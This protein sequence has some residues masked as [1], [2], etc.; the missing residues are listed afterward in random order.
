MHLTPAQRDALILLANETRAQ[1]AA[2][3]SAGHVW[4]PRTLVARLFATTDALVDAGLVRFRVVEHGGGSGR[5]GAGRWRSRAVREL[6][7]TPDG[8]LQVAAIRAAVASQPE[9]NPAVHWTEAQVARV[10]RRLG[11]DFARIP[12]AEFRRG[13]SVELEHGRHGPGGRA[14]DVTHDSALLTGKIALA[15]LTEDPHYYTKLRRVEDN[16]R[17][18]IADVRVQR[19]IRG[20]APRIDASAKARGLEILRQRGA[21]SGAEYGRGMQGLNANPETVELR[22]YTQGTED[23]RAARE[24]KKLIA[25]YERQIEASHGKPGGTSLREHLHDTIRRLRQVGSEE[26]EEHKNTRM[27][28]RRAFWKAT[29]QLRWATGALARSQPVSAFWHHFAEWARLELRA[30]FLAIVLRADLTGSD[31]EDPALRNH[32][33]NTVCRPL[34]VPLYGLRK[35]ECL[36][37]WMLQHE[38]EHRARLLERFAAARMVTA[39]QWEPTQWSIHRDVWDRAKANLISV[40]DRYG[41]AD[42]GPM[43]ASQRVAKHNRLSQVGEPL[44]WDEVM[45]GLDASYTDPQHLGGAGQPTRELLRGWLDRHSLEGL[46]AIVEREEKKAKRMREAAEE[47][48]ARPPPPPEPPPPP[49]EPVR[50]PP[51]RVGAWKEGER[52]GALFGNPAGASLARLVARAARS[53]RSVGGG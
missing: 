18:T 7:L 48:P 43:P 12:F 25:K 11:V 20:A 1:T 51:R 33:A 45:D 13:M 8:E 44:T 49:P 23:P 39:Q 10:G 22:Y 27:H 3:R 19:A 29:E 35:Y 15:H 50:A 4:I 52:Q 41:Y 24:R 17:A 46:E 14:L 6:Q 40:N 36:N 42:P 21:L 31:T 37:A 53:A 47:A 38:L 2:G 26:R 16:P 28:Y 5:S 9:P 34:H 32:G 30:Q